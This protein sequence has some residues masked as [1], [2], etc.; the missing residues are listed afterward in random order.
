MNIRTF[1][2]VSIYIQLFAHDFTL[3]QQKNF[4]PVGR[5]NKCNNSGY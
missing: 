4:C 1:A 5:S 2:T 3:P